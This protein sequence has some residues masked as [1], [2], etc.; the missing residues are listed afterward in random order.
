MRGDEEFAAVVM[1]NY[2]WNLGT[3]WLNAANFIFLISYTFA[4]NIVSLF[5]ASY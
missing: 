1:T 3:C 5:S 2:H 4:I